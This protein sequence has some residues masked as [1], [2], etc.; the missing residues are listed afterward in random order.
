MMKQGKT[1]YDRVE[2]E[3]DWSFISV[4]SNVNYITRT[5]R[6]IY[7][8]SSDTL[9]DINHLSIATC[10]TILAKGEKAQEHLN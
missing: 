1:F 8:C 5:S 6:S 9:V 7:G 3:E 4:Q 10:L 2:Y